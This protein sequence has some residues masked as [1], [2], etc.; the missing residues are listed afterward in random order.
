MGYYTN[1]ELQNMGFKYIGKHVMV[2]TMARIYNPE[3]TELHDFCRIDD[4]CV[5]MGKVTLGRYVHL[6]LYTHIGGTDEGV[7]F[8]DHSECAY[9]CTVITHS[10]DYSLKT[11]H[12]PS[13]PSKYKGGRAGPVRIGKYSL[14]GCD[15]L[16]MPNVTIAQGCSFGAFSFVSKDCDAWGMYDGKP[17]VRIRENSRACIKLSEELDES[18]ILI[19]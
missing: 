11:L 14:L 10:S 19:G 12:T 18:S 17:A 9:R 13:T 7:I 2:S 1:K 3:K 5:L 15:T 6:A 16:V 8:E 4:F